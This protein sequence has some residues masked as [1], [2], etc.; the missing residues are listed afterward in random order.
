[1]SVA[2][3]TCNE[4]MFFLTSLKILKKTSVNSHENTFILD[5]YQRFLYLTSKDSNGV[6]GIR[7]KLLFS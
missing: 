3:V 6:V 2:F 4:E 7:H 1:M 5:D